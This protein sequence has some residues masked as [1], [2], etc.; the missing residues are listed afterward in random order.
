MVALPF[1]LRRFREL[2]VVDE[3]SEQA[4]IREGILTLADMDLAIA[5]ERPVTA[6]AT[7]RR[8]AGML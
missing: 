3:M 5:D 1:L 2:R 8:A 4:L 7:L 6:D